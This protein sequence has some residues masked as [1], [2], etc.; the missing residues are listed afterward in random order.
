MPK[1]NTLREAVQRYVAPFRDAIR[2]IA[3][4]TLITSQ[5]H[6]YRVNG[7]YSLILNN[8]DPV[9]L[10]S[11]P[12]ISLSAG[13]RFRIVRDDDLERGPYRVH[14]VEYWYLFAADDD[15]E[16]LTFHWT[17]AFFDVVEGTLLI[18]LAI[19]GWSRHRGSAR[20]VSRKASAA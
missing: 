18:A 6:V 11:S 3:H 7:V 9:Q 8:S 2:C 5:E 20:K 16:M 14:T 19:G 12:A 10:R 1:Q 17:P 13:Q 15:R 4:G